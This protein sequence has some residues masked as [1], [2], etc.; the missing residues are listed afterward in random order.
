MTRPLE[1]QYFILDSKKGTLSV[2]NSLSSKRAND[3]IL[4]PQCL[5]NFNTDYSIVNKDL[6]RKFEI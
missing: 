1:R 2:F 5:M 3:L 6:S 4:L